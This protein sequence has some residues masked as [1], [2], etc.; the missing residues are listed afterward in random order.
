MS[1]TMSAIPRVASKTNAFERWLH[2]PAP[3]ERLAGLRI[4]IGAFVTIYLLANVREVVLVSRQPEQAFDP[5]GIARLLNAPLPSTW[6]WIGYGLALVSGVLF[7]AGALV[8]WS[9]P[10]FAL[11]VLGWTSLHSSWGQTLH[12]EHLFS[13]H[14]LILAL[15][16]TADA[17]SI[18]SSSKTK[19]AARTPDVRYGWPIRL[20]AIATAITYV[21]SGIAKLRL[22]GGDWFVADTLANHI[23]YSASRMQFIGGPTPPL[24]SVALQASWL[25]PVVAAAVLVTELGAPFAL[26]GR[27]WRN[28]W[29]TMA[30]IFHLG[31]AAT[32]WVFFG[33]RGL[34][35]GLLPLFAVEK[36]PAHLARLTHRV[37]PRRTV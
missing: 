36:L 11:V 10:I 17:W 27:R 15:A 1:D 5:I 8:R 20:L 6:L 13:L 22:S 21:L 24:A 23:G 18:T 12:F 35:I 31:T 25:L 37:K 26:A 19:T 32:M 34:G 2:Q 3:A 30:V 7:T 4:A 28:G 14:L 29:V 33:Y 9:G 16:P